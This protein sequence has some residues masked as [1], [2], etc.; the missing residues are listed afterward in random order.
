M[1]VSQTILK[2]IKC[3]EPLALFAWGAKDILLTK[4]GIRFKSSGMAKWK[5]HIEIKYNSSND[6]YDIHFFK[7]L[8][9]S[10]KST[11]IEEGVYFDEMV[12]VIDSVVQ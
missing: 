11:R 8:K 3:L 1:T 10:I 2:Q 4:N 6:L 5:G 7:I 9:G 12:G